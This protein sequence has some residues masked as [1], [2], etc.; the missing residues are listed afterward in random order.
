MLM[1]LINDMMDLAKTEHMKFDLNNKPF[2]L[3]QTIQR[4]FESMDF[5]AIEKK[6]KL[7]LNI[8]DKLLPFL[9]NLIGDEA[10]Y[11]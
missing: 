10:R 7:V 8:N 6:V 3:T 2:D 9:R 11:N 1:N 4:S 5:L